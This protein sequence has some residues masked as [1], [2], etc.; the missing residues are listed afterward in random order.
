MNVLLLNTTRVIND[1][2]FYF[3]LFERLY[4]FYKTLLLVIALGPATTTRFFF[5]I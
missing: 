1:S 5:D 2:C 3:S 4:M